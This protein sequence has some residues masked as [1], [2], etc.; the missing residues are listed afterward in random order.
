[1]ALGLLFAMAIATIQPAAALSE[2]QKVDQ[3]ASVIRSFLTDPNFA[4]MRAV[5]RQARGVVIIPKF[6]PG[7]WGVD[8]DD[9][10]VLMVQREDGTWSHPAFYDID[11]GSVSKGFWSRGS[12]VVLL[13]MN[14]RALDTLLNAYQKVRLGSQLSLTVGPVGG[15]APAPGSDLISYARTYQGYSGGSVAG[16][17]LE[18]DKG[19]NQ[20]Y[21]GYGAN[22]RGI[23]VENRFRNGGADNLR[24]AMIGR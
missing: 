21:Y 5:L 4:G 7:L 15:G 9:D 3:A 11:D 12:A 16:A 22:P 1:M 8:G 6:E 18:V 23:A 17:D 2:Q 24:N 14:D 20:D 10:A 19:D 13:V